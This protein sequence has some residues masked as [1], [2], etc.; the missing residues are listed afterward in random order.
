M[1]MNQT[2]KN[3][4]GARLYTNIA[5]HILLWAFIFGLPF[6][7]MERGLSFNWER[8]YNSI[9]S[10]LAFATIFYVNYLY[11]INA[12]L[13]KG[14]TKEFIVLNI[15]LI[16]VL[17]VLMHVWHDFQISLQQDIHPRRFQRRKAASPLLFI[18]RNSTSLLLVGGLSVAIRMS[19]RWFQV[20]TERKELEKAKTEAELQ[21]IKNQINPHF[22][23]NTLNNVYALIE[24]NP[25]KAQQ[26][27]LDLSKLLRH[28]LYDN[29]QTFVPLRQEADFIQN[30]IELMR[31]RLPD[32]VQL[33]TH[34]SYSET[35]H[36]VIAP[37]IFISLIENA[38]KH[39]IS[40]DKPSF[41]SVSLTEVGNGTVIFIS[42]NSCFP[43]SDTDR[44][45]SGIGTKLVRKRLELLYHNR[46]SWHTIV[47]NDVYTTE[48]IIDTQIPFL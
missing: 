43:K 24:F 17:A 44:S 27:V 32:N 7:F 23:L 48:L 21:N 22:L 4:D 28:L 1:R 37:L 9:P 31:I 20:E 26:A 41:I 34:I 16:I 5:V 42:Q 12:F 36:T 33:D 18:V 2:L 10:L 13:F 8:F 29:N 3:R 15:V 46:Y 19:G 47:E 35:E 11:L 30:Y 14:K 39:G 6:F 40:A 25:P 45:G 38:F